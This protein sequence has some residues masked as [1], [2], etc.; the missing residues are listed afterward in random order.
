MRFLTAGESHGKGLTILIDDVPA[1]LSLS[2]E[3]INEDLGRRQ[4]GYGRG[5][6]M[7]IETDK[8]EFLSGVRF[9]KTTGAPISLFVKNK[10]FANWTEIMAAEGEPVEEKKFIRPRPG[11]ADLAGFYKYDLEDLRDSLERSSARETAARVAAG[12]VAKALL[13]QFGVTV[14]SHVTQLGGMTIE[15]SDPAA[16]LADF[17]SPCRGE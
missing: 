17:A 7:R 6:R 13:S 9:G 2:S 1:G 11:H 12:A 14:F 15:P 8:V 5:G 10:D 16:R 3:L 4:Q